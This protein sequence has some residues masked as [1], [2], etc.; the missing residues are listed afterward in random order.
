MIKSKIIA[1]EGRNVDPHY[2]Y[3]SRYTNKE[4]EEII[5]IQFILVFDIF[6]VQQNILWCNQNFKIMN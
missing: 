6:V 5:Y 2:L 4:K 1:V 3:L